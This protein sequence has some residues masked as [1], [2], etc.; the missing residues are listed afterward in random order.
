MRILAVLRLVR[1]GSP[2]LRLSSTGQISPGKQAMAAPGITRDGDDL[3]VA[4]LLYF[5][6]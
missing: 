4:G 1:S 5:L 3:M 6:P 2:D